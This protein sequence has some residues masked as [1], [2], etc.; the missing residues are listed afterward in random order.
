MWMI[1]SSWEAR[2]DVGADAVA[3]QDDVAEMKPVPFAGATS[4]APA[5]SANSADVPRSERSM[6]R[7]STSAPITST[8]S[9]RP[10]STWAAASASADRK[11]VQAAPTSIAPARVAPSSRATSGAA[12]GQNR[13]GGHR[14]DQN[15]VHI[16]GC[17]V[18]LR[19]R[20]AAGRGGEVLQA[21]AV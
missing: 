5:P 18:R 17:D 6:K 9:L 2:I 10:P 13:V 19:Q 15:E 11:P 12:F 21:L 4:A 7:L 20:G 16:L 1:C 3:V 8:L 14:R